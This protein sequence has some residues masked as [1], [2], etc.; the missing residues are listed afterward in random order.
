MKKFLRR[1]DW[2]LLAAILV[3]LTFGLTIIRSVSPNLLWTQFTY[4]LIS[5]AAFFLFSQIDF[6]IYEK[7]V[8]FFYLGSLIFLLATF[9]FGVITRGA[10]R[11]IQIGQLTVQPSELVKPFLIIFFAYHLASLKDF[12]FGRALASLGLLLLPAILIFRQP[13]LGSSLLVII[14]WLAVL[15]AS[16]AEFRWILGG[17][18]IVSL[19][20]PLGWRFLAPYQ[21]ERLSS[22]VDPL[23]DPLGAGFTV[24]QA[25]TAVGSGQFWG[26]GLG[27]G[28]QSHLRFLPER[29]TDFIFASLGEE[30][31]FLGTTVLLASFVILFWRI[32]RAAEGAKD[33]A[34]FCFCLGI[35]GLL[36]SQVVINIGMNL[37]LVPIT[38]ITLPLVSYGGSS[39]LGTM[40]ALGMVESVA[41]DKK[42]DEVIEIK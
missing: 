9:L 19:L 16:G 20:L 38:G 5:L 4:S 17:L 31:G 29:H 18:I 8:V 15:V 2:L 13:D 25:M 36:F 26:R 35:F 42:R 32:L 6:R 33:R 22:F 34:G 39:L 1:F 3:C 21:Q 14:A 12:S 27:W 37:G 41:R 10:V 24:I 28:T 7:T 40:V 23:K 11:W 30:L